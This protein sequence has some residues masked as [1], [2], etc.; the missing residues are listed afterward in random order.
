MC[1]RDRSASTWSL[2]GRRSVADMD[3]RSRG[4]AGVWAE[5]APC[6]CAATQAQASHAG[7][8]ADTLIYTAAWPFVDTRP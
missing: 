2:S 7:R 6:R 4:G 8:A 3:G 5:I 1:I